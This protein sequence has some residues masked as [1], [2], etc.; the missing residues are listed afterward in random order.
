VYVTP[1][2]YRTMGYGVDITDVEDVEL[3]SIL[4]RAS[5]MVDAICAVPKIP[6]KFDFRGGSITGER[7]EWYIDAYERPHPYRFRVFHRP[8]KVISKFRIYSSPTIYV[9]IPTA[10]MMINISA[11]YAEIASL[12][13]TQFGIWGAGI[14]PLMG[15][16]NPIYEVDYTYGYVFA[17][18]D[19][20]LEATDAAYYR[21]QHQWWNADPV[22]KKNGI[23]LTPTTDYTV[24]LNEGTVTLTAAPTATDVVSATYTHRLPSEI[25]DATAMIA[26]HMI[27]ERE[28]EERGMASVGTL[29]VAEVRISR[30]VEHGTKTLTSELDP[31]VASLL[32]PFIFRTVR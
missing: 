13:L 26:T 15:L 20:I 10:D 7:H 18:G 22:I 8:V 25:Q 21:A 17:E 9:E 28:M 19:E 3:R 2:R 27:G 12:H 32:E 1:E 16:Y 11:G 4:T 5:S 31:E 29:S 6:Q 30:A 14:V 23:T 24:D